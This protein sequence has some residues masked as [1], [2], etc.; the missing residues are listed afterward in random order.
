MHT[1]I[2]IVRKKVLPSQMQDEPSEAHW[3]SS[4]G[5]K[6]KPQQTNLSTQ[7]PPT[8]LKEKGRELC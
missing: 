1:L 4:N 8:V 5:H 2:S 6:K 7:Q 3:C